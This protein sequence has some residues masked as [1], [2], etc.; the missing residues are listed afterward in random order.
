MATHQSHFSL[1]TPRSRT[2]I[3]QTIISYKSCHVFS[4][5]CS[6]F[7]LFVSQY[8]TSNIF[9][10]S[11]FRQFHTIFWTSAV[12]RYRPHSQQL[13]DH[14]SKKYIS[15]WPSVLSLP[16]QRQVW[17]IPLAAERG[18][19]RY[20]C[21]IPWERVPY[22]SA[23]DVCSRRDVIHVYLTL[24]YLRSSLSAYD[25]GIIGLPIALIATP[26]CFLKRNQHSGNWLCPHLGW[27]FGPPS[28]SQHH[29]WQPDELADVDH[30][31]W[32]L[33]LPNRHSLPPAWSTYLYCCHR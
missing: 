2:Y 1:S 22:L 3:R 31:I 11:K 27:N 17:F 9:R 21:E 29:W 8:M 26:V 20:N 33:L 18:V 32:Y 14:C 10:Y 15:D 13:C 30:D 23:L 7:A 6:V 28:A 12:N 24:P 16:W 5:F 4:S 19:C 25:N